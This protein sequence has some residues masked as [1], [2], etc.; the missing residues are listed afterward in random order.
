M[1]GLH[2]TSLKH[3][4]R[5]DLRASGRILLA[6][7][8]AAVPTL[9]LIQLDGAGVGIVNLVVGGLV[10]LCAYVTLAPILGAVE[11][12]DILN[13]KTLLSHTQV[14]AVLANPV[15]NYESKILSMVKR[16]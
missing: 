16:N 4:A 10:Y 13:L 9:G 3:D 5:P 11:K 1:Y 8:A 7:F 2:E 6:A 12:Q 14:L 15:F